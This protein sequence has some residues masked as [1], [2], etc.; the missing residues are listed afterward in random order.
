MSSTHT[1]PA[2]WR[3]L[4]REKK[5]ALAVKLAG[6]PRW[7][8]KPDPA[9][10]C[11]HS[12]TP[13]Q[14]EFLALTCREALFGGSAG[15]GKSD[16]MLM[17]ALQYV[18]VPGYAAL[19]LRRTFRQLELPDAVMARSH[20]W[21]QGTDARWSAAKR[22]W[23]FPSGATV[24]FGHLQYDVNKF[25]YQGPAWHSIL[26]DELGQFTEGMYTY[27]F[28]RLRRL[29]GFPVPVRMRATANPGGI[30]HDFV[31]QRFMVEGP[32]KGRVF[33]PSRLE[34]NPYLDREEYAATLQ[35]LD[36]VTRAQLL[37]GDWDI[38]PQGMLFR[39]EWFELV[40]AAPVECRWVRYWDLAATEAKAGTDPDWT[41]GCRMGRTRAGEYYI[42]DV[43]RLR[44]TPGAVERAIR[45]TAELDGTGTL[46]YLEQEP[47]ASGKSVVA[48][49]R[50]LLDGYAFRGVRST[51]DKVTRAQ[52]L[53]AQAEAGNV[54]L[55]RGGWIREALEEV[56][57]FP[58]EGLHDDQVDAMS[59]AL[60]QLARAPEF[61]AL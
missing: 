44:A 26:F 31:K 18:H 8:L 39:R 51:G 49:Y 43:V 60:S 35:E 5:L 38:R 20:Q 6:L 52:P 21:L 27:L 54:K 2:D 14:A 17:A 56:V 4:P 57:A 55:V 29:K 24:T 32:E 36:P 7:N 11:P 16:A 37:H 23:Q 42:S 10:Y 33:I 12:P 50:R 15:G 47:G 58:A 13:K 53:S 30:G 41:A 61:G 1:Y 46:I 22:Q 28:S 25:D 45:Q 59:G 19:I 48:S 3:A 9:R 34:D 40:D